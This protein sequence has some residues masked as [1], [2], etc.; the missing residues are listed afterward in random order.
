MKLST[1][2]PNK[3]S[4][5]HRKPG[6]AP[7]QLTRLQQIPEEHQWAPPALPVGHQVT[8]HFAVSGGISLRATKQVQQRTTPQ[9]LLFK[10]M[11]V[12][13]FFFK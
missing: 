2:H 7:Q 1:L 4:L 13:V 6:Q 5:C 12:F 9:S 10:A 11:E 3:K 8:Q